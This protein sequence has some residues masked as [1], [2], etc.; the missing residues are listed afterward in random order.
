M[1]ADYLESLSSASMEASARATAGLRTPAEARQR[2]AVLRARL[3]TML[4]AFPARTPLHARRM[5]S[6]DRGGYTIEKIIFESRPG[7]YVTA[8]VYV[9]KDFQP[10]F[11]AVL[12]PVGHWGQGKA[13]E[14]YQK[15]GIYLSRHG[16][17]VLVY[18]AVGQ[19]ERLQYY[20]EVLGRSVVDPGS[21][22]Y[23]VTVEHGVAAGQAFL[24]HGD[25]S[26]YLAWDG[27]RA[28]DYLVE[29]KDVD[30][31]RIACTG[32]SG[33][34]LQTELLSALDSRIRVAIPVSYGGCSADEP[35][36][37]DF[38]ALDLDVLTAP[39]PMLMMAAT[40]DPASG[41]AWKRRRHGALKALYDLF[42]A[43]SR[44]DFLVV[45]ARHG[46]TEGGR[47]AALKWLDRWLRPAVSARQDYREAPAA[48]E[49]EQSL[50]CTATGQVLTSLGGETVNSL[51]R[52]EAQAAPPPRWPQRKEDWHQWKSDRRKQIAAR[53]GLPSASQPVSGETFSSAGHG[54]YSIERLIY[55]W[56][57]DMYVPALL[58]L[59]RRQGPRPAVI[60][61]QQE[62]KS[63]A[64]APER[65]LEVLA[66]AGYAVLSIDLSGT[67]ETAPLTEP[68]YNQRNYRGF[69]ED[70]E[71]DLFYDAIYAGTSLAGIR[72]RD[73]LS[74]VEYLQGRKEVDGGAIELIGRGMGAL[75]VLYAAALDDR[76]AGVTLD[77]VLASYRLILAS[78]LYTQRLANFVP[79]ALA[80]F[81]LPELA[82][83]IAPRPLRIMN[84]VDQMHRPLD[85]RQ[86][87]E[88]Y[89][90]VTG[91][92]RL[93]GAGG[94]FLLSRPLSPDAVLQP[95][96]TPRP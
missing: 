82:G 56:R 90:Q 60:Y 7:Y 26:S 92:Y 35:R 52:A 47:Q 79:A 44:T 19:G 89:R 16:Y 10:P 85:S 68:P 58:F 6:L 62:G 15:L 29:R 76:I 93:L 39:R 70:S 71:A 84:P 3:L 11:P 22:Q 23:Y 45:D 59:P 83:L 43:G 27:L 21:S 80:V 86:A 37:P 48:L 25:F 61:V 38:S 87:R 20:N 28:L 78:D 55:R 66:R 57:P 49:S 65:H 67:G 75:P 1:V 34:G 4:G 2:Q 54:A 24:A 64:G 51:A 88:T 96:L 17:L 30:R 53:I 14:D 12:C 74:A 94:K 46:Y 91:T 69:T 72:T 9:P 50:A 8:N 63:A 18:D 31:E 5:G 13:F 95:Y 81:D 33:G 42:G 40:G 73:V 41:V 77:G 36:R 32:A